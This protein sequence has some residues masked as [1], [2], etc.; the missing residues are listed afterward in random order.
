MIGVNLAGAE[1]GT[2]N[3]Y[4]YD[5]IYPNSAELDYYKAHGI[6][7]VRLP[8][9]WERMQ[10]TL[11][12]SLDSAELQRLTTFLSA[13]QA[14]GIEVTL[15]V[16]DFGRYGG[17]V[18]GSTD[19]PIA[20]FAD[21][22]TKLASAV[23]GF[24]NIWG[25]D[26]MNEPH[27]M[28]GQWAAAAQ[29]AV[30]GIRTV[31][32]THTILVEGDAW[33]TA[34][35]WQ[36]YNANL[37]VN[38]PAHKLMYEAHQYFDANNS[39]T[40]TQSYDQQGAYATIGVDRLAP[41]VTWLQQHGAQ[42]FIGEFGVPGNDPRWLTVLDNFVAAMQASGLSGTYWA[43]GPWWGNYALSIEPSNGQDKP[44]MDVLEK[45]TQVGAA[46]G[47][48]GDDT[49]T[50]GAGNNTL[51]GGA[52]DDTAVFPLSLAAY[53]PQDLG[54][55]II[56]AGPD[57]NTT[58]RAI[59]HL[60]FADGT[61]T[62]DDGNPVFDTLYYDRNNPDVFHAGVNA[63]AH[64][65]AAGW[66]EGRDPNAYFSV[67]QYLNANPSVRASG[68]NPLDHYHQ[69]GWRAGLD[70]SAS[71]DTRLYLAHNPDVAAAGID[72]LV[73]YLASGMAEG[74]VAYAAIGHSV[75]GFDAEYYLFH[76]PDIAAA[77]IDPLQ[78]YNTGRL[79]RGTRSQSLL[80][81]VGVS[82]ALCGYRGCRR[83]SVAAL[84]NGGMA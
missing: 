61:V 74:R 47:N 77:G 16:H 21:F 9:K 60:R 36:A 56:V 81:Y 37:N 22:W 20:S 12:G 5:Y 71:F 46:I 55:K 6:E 32:T 14:R 63:L 40:Y 73:H 26:L 1:F 10:P 29:A 78:H 33:S 45:Y 57:G 3:R 4:G 35:T 43:G 18:I 28:N 44:Q 15:D 7:L 66:H 51:D 65:N 68:M 31:D 39:G 34:S 72:P 83:K 84:R 50:V 41:F 52:G 24:A 19:V 30:N 79:A 59:E 48:A 13:A 17:K 67:T 38:D 62:P 69:I 11:G 42:G 49:L 23:K 64:F 8:F 80:R 25:Y 82:R 27:N 2:G 53:S 70:P 76:N 54:S 58:L 75:A